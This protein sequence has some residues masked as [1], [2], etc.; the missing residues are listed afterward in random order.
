MKTES[1]IEV[2]RY[3]DTDGILEVSTVDKRERVMVRFGKGYSY[4]G[5]PVL[6]LRDNGNGFDVKRYSFVPNF[7]N[8]RYNIE[9]DEA[10]YLYLALKQVFEHG[11]HNDR[12]R[13]AGK[14]A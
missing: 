5:E 12:V 13:K 2:R 6:R 14:H 10:E 11:H 1:N 3:R 8:K 9:Y 7:A 4:P